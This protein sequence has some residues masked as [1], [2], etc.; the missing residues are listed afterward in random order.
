MNTEQTIRGVIIDDEIDGREVIKKII[1][2]RVPDLE[3]VGEADSVQNGISIIE[4]SNPNLIFLDIGLKDGTGF[5]ILEHFDKINFEIIFQ[6][7]F[8]QF[9]IRA[10]KFSA[11]DYILKPIDASEL[12]KA[13][14]KA[15]KKIESRIDI[16]PNI[17]Q[18]KNDL[19]KTIPDKIALPTEYGYVFIPILDIIRCQAESNY[20]KFFLVNKST[21]ITCHTLGEYEKLL[22]DCGFIRVH[23]SHLINL[24]FIKS[25]NRG[26][27]GFITMSDGSEIEV[28]VRRKDEFFNQ[29]SKILISSNQ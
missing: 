18:L 29:L 3:I 13:I 28:S 6:T 11:L 15:R 22:S 4:S 23:N 25:Y 14:E 20:T 17:N 10:I 8:N 1:S 24:K 9:A 5:D 21:I 26:K 16:N 27:G 19:K 12:L 7:A 2:N